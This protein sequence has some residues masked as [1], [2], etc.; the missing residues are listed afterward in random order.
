MFFSSLPILAIVVPCYKEEEVLPETN[1][2]L[3]NLLKIMGGVKMSR[4][5]VL[6]SM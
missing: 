4:P 2:R 1:E 6:Y 3:L 5:K